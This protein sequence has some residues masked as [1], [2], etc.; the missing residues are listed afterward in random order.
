MF[1]KTLS[2]SNTL[3][4]HE[5]AQGMG[6]IVCIPVSLSC[7]DCPPC[8]AEAADQMWASQQHSPWAETPK[9]QRLLLEP[10][11]FLKFNILQ[12]CWA[13]PKPSV[14]HLQPVRMLVLTGGQ[15]EGWTNQ[16]S[17]LLQGSRKC[18][19]G[20]TGRVALLCDFCLQL[21]PLWSSGPRCL[22]L[23]LKITE[24][25]QMI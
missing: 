21:R 23:F 3:G 10:E 13:H 11:E 16:N 12:S 8:C 20:P 14:L 2:S 17:S 9:G 1:S 15:R 6:V 22:F 5:N 4:L 24:W 18:V 25:S 7:G 19:R